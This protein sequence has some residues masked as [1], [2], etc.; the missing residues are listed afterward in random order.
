MNCADVTAA[1]IDHEVMELLKR[2]YERAKELL[3]GNKDV[4]ERIAAFL[5]EK[6][7][8]SGKEFMELF[9]ELRPEA[10]AEAERKKAEKEEKAAKDA[11]KAANETEK[12]EV[13]EEVN[14]A[15]VIVSAETVME[16]DD[17]EETN[18]E[19]SDS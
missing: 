17:S 2:C 16:S 3:S 13:T 10:K 8:I 15:E 1:E 6:E 12:S 7:T 9:Y 4:M 5:I 18:P 11:Q 19:E 14:D